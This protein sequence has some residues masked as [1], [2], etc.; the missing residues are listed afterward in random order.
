MATGASA[1]ADVVTARDEEICAALAPLLREYGLPFVGI[2]V[3]G[4]L[5]TEVN[6]TSPTGLR[7]ID[8]LTGS[9]LARDIISWVTDRV[10]ACNRIGR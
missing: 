10:H 9:N 8:A 3:T 7:E 6:V 2:D 5:L 1:I 4:G